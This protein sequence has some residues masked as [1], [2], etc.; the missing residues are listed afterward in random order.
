M[1]LPD[2]RRSTTAERPTPNLRTLLAADR[3]SAPFRVSLALLRSDGGLRRFAGFALGLATRLQP[4]I[5]Q[6]FQQTELPDLL[7]D[8]IAARTDFDQLVHPEIRLRGTTLTATHV[9]AVVVRL[10]GAGGETLHLDVVLTATFG[11][12]VISLDNGNIMRVNATALETQTTL[13]VEGVQAF[14]H[15]TPL[16]KYTHAYGSRGGLEDLDQDHYNGEK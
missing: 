11:E 8:A 3:R 5:D 14:T 7:R 4:I 12:L 1:N 13:N 16:G 10:S 9:Y 6:E 15:T 2:P